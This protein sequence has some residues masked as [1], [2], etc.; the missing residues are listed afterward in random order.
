MALKGGGRRGGGAGGEPLLH[1]QRPAAPTTDGMVR[2]LLRARTELGM[3][4]RDDPDDLAARVATLPRARVTMHTHSAV[5]VDGM[6]A[7]VE[8]FK[9]DFRGQWAIEGQTASNPPTWEEDLYK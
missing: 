7:I 8:A 5:T 3:N 2:A 1:G 4:M 6:P 9:T